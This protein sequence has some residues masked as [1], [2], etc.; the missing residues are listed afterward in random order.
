M[1]ESRIDG[2]ATE[3]K[4]G[5]WERP[6]ILRT[7]PS[8]SSVLHFNQSYFMDK[9]VPP[10]SR[11]C[12]ATLRISGTSSRCKKNIKIFCKISL[13]ESRLMPY[14]LRSANPQWQ[15][16]DWEGKTLLTDFLM[17]LP[18]QN[19]LQDSSVCYRRALY[20]ETSDKFMQV[21]LIAI[22]I[23][24]RLLYVRASREYFSFS[25]HKN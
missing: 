25:E 21:N 11:P 4:W 5:A 3:L 6:R 18:N 1:L 23:K 2:S 9:F 10:T 19:N 14:D 7:I 16:V 24:K 15:C 13:S 12:A 20:G 17:L 8:K 22:G